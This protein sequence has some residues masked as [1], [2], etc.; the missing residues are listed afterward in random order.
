MVIEVSRRL[1][2]R[3][4]RGPG[5][6]CRVPA[7]IL[8]ENQFEFWDVQKYF[9]KLFACREK[10]KLNIVGWTLDLVIFFFGSKGGGGG[11]IYRHRGIYR[12]IYTVKDNGYLNV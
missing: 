1:M 9:G 12:Y 2:D 10:G 7:L 4:V 8:V 5:A 6:G 11:G 3:S